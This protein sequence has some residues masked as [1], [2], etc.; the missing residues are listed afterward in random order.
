M[1]VVK[2]TTHFFL[3]QLLREAAKAVKSRLSIIYVWVRDDKTDEGHK[4]HLKFVET[5]QLL[6][7]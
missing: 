1:L 7:S 4:L 5:I 6:V 3:E 2:R